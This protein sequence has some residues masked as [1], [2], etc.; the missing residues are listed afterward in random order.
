MIAAQRLMLV[1][2]ALVSALLSAC[3]RP[4]NGVDGRPTEWR[5]HPGVIAPGGTIC[6]ATRTTALVEYDAELADVEARVDRQVE[7]QGWEQIGDYTIQTTRNLL[8][9]RAG[10]SLSVEIS[11]DGAYTSVDY[12]AE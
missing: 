5:E 7:G 1:S 11:D 8:Y 9:R 6:I 10:R 2:C 3:E 4:C 12:L